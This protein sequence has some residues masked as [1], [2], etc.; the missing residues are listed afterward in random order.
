MELEELLER[1]AVVMKEKPEC[2]LILGVNKK[3]AIKIHKFLQKIA[4]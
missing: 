4:K 3:Q 1:L 2:I